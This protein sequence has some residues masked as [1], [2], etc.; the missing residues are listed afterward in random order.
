QGITHIAPAVV[1]L[2]I[3]FIASKAGA[4]VP[5]AFAIAFTIMLLQGVSLTQL[6]RHLPSAGGYYTYVSRPVHPRAGLLTAWLYLLYDPTATAINLAFLSK[7]LEE[8]LGLP[9]WLLFPAGA[10]L[11]T[12]LAYRGIEVSAR[13]MAVL[14]SAEI[15][16][17][18][19][20]GVTGLL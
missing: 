2:V 6:A 3:P 12:V 16:I 13:T 5:L 11:V 9:W 17:A 20:L 15:A 7:F 1:L 10:A 4:A 8:P 14:G 19:A 18:V